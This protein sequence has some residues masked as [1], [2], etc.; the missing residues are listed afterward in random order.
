MYGIAILLVLLSGLLHSIWNL[1]TKRSLNKVV[2]LWLT[3]L[4]AI[5]VFTPLTIVEWDIS[6]MTGLGGFMLLFSML[7]HGVYV[8]LLARTYTVGDFSQVYPIMRGTSPLVVPILGTTLLGEHLSSLGWLGVSLIVVSIG[9]TSNLRW[10]RDGSASPQSYRAPLLAL[11]VG[12]CIASYI[13][14]DKI[15]LDYVPAVMLNQATNVGNALLLGLAAIRSRAVKS[16]LKI[17]RKTILLGGILA[18]GGYMLFLYALSL[19]PV[20]Q[21]APMREIG[22]VFGTLMGIFLLKE[23]Q[24]KQRIGTSILITTGV[25]LL[26]MNS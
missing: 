14:V 24:G 22:T 1:Y 8:L 20:A 2:F 11:S 5:L 21:L 18:P 25:I 10:K 6:R 13:V 3:Q 7:L 23:P 26:A 4:V 16:E 12:L 15:A 9:F 17:N 19:A